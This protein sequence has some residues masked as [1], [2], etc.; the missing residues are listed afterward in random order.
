MK[1][2]KWYSI[3]TQKGVT[4]LNSNNAIQGVGFTHTDTGVCPSCRITCIF[5]GI[6]K[7]HVIQIIPDYAPSSFKKFIFWGQTE[8]SEMEFLF[9]IGSIRRIGRDLNFYD[10]PLAP[11][12]KRN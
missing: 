3:G 2:K 1:S 12:Q 7:T 8:L 4:C 11:P 6:G 9:L 10:P 5:Y